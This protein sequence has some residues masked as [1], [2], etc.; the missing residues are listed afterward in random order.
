MS[1]PFRLKQSC[2]SSAQDVRGLE[3]AQQGLTAAFRFQVKRNGLLAGCLSHERSAH[4]TVIHGSVGAC[5]RARLGLCGNSTL[6]IV[7][8]GI[9]G[10][11]LAA[12]LQLAGRRIIL[13]DPTDL[14]A[15]LPLL[16]DPKRCCEIS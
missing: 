4:P 14:Q 12:Q 1:A 9:D 6:I 15:V 5:I 3:Q 16:R 13:F 2:Q 7:G 8:T 10:L 11:A